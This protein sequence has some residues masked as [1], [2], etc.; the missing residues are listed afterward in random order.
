[1]NLQNTKTA[2]T[3]DQTSQDPPFESGKTILINWII[4]ALGLGGIAA[5]GS[6]LPELL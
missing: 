3:P 6:I 2:D 5:L 4:V 1:M